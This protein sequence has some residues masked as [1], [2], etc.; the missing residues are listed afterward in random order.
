VLG[1]CASRHQHTSF[2]QRPSRHGRAIDLSSRAHGTEKLPAS[3]SDALVM[4]REN[5]LQRLTCW[6]SSVMFARVPAPGRS[7][8]PACT[9][10]SPLTRQQRYRQ[11]GLYRDSIT[12]LQHPVSTLQAV[13]YRTY[14]QDS[15]FRPVVSLCRMGVEPTGLHRKVSVRYIELPPFPGLSWRDV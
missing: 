13:R 6:H 1:A 8:S 12:R 4:Q 9:V 14:M 5:D 11:H 7:P 2:A 10:L 3:L 15:R